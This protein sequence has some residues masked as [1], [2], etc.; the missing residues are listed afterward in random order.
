MFPERFPEDSPSQ[1]ERRVFQALQDGLSDEYTVLAQA[2]GSLTATA[3]RA[4]VR[5]TSLSS[6]PSAA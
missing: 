3:A 2:V 5:P 6:T 4:R 1:A